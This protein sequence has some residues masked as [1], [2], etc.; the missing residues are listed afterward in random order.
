METP[1]H[2]SEKT[3]QPN[4]KYKQQNEIQCITQLAKVSIDPKFVELTADVFRIFLCKSPIFDQNEENC[5]GQGQ[6]TG[7][8]Y[9]PCVAVYVVTLT[10]TQK[11]SCCFQ[12]VV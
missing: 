11:K 2:G 1:S 5:C 4:S 8:W 10:L 3:E 9:L 12:T 7:E 6:E